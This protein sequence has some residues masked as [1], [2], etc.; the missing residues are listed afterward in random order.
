[1][2]KGEGKKDGEVWRVFCGPVPEIIPKQFVGTLSVYALKNSRWRR[3][4]D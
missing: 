4:T 2:E 3:H 1:M